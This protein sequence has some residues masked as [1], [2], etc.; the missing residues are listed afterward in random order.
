[1]SEMGKLAGGGLPEPLIS[2]FINILKKINSGV[3]KNERLE[4]SK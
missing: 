4:V 1:M 2:E 3:A